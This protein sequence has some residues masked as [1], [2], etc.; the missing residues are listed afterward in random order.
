MAKINSLGKGQN[1]GTIDKQQTNNFYGQP[2]E[3]LQL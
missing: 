3:N 1:G 2:N